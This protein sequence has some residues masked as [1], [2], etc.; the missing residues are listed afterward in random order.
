VHA[1]I[2]VNARD[3][4][5]ERERGSQEQQRVRHGLPCFMAF[6]KV[7]TSVSSSAS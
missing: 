3:H 2:H 6:T 1:E 5:T 4:E 7:D